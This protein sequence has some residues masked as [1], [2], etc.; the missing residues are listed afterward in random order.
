MYLND[1]L[2]YEFDGGAL[3]NEYLTPME[4]MELLRIGKNKIYELLASGALPAIRLGKQWRISRRAILDLE[5]R[6]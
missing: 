3:E 5:E 4:A 2:L 6:Y 1:Q